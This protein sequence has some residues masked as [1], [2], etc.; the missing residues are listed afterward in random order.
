MLNSELDPEKFHKDFQ[1]F[2]AY[3]EQNVAAPFGPLSPV[4]MAWLDETPVA[5][6]GAPGRWAFRNGRVELNLRPGENLTL[7]EQALNPAD[8]EVTVDLG[9]VDVAGIL[10]RDG[11]K[12]IEVALRGARPI[13]RPRDPDSPARRSHTQVPTFPADPAWV[14]EATF[15]PYEQPRQITVGAVLEGVEHH[16]TALGTLHFRVHGTPQQLTALATGN[17]RSLGLHF[18]DATAG[19]TTWG[20]V[21]V[22][23][24]TLQPDGRSALIDFNRTLNQPC[25][26]TDHA[27]CPLPPAGNHLDVEITA[28]EQIPTTRK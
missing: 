28:G 1:A 23:V 2:R 10:L 7:D 25:A 17:P 3:R 9:A 18:T 16:H 15:E 14:I 6:T 19:K 4:G 11:V 12:R 21:R 13:V 5:V 27:T 26:F 20:E 8:T 22:N 24:A